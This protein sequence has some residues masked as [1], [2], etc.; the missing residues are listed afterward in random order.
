MAVSSL[1][2][3][4]GAL[5][6]LF[7]IK[8]NLDPAD[9]TAGGRGAERAIRYGRPR[10]VTVMVR[11]FAQVL[12]VTYILTGVLGFLFTGFQGGEVIT[13]L[14]FDFNPVHNALHAVVG[15]AFLASSVNEGLARSV[16]TL[17]GGTYL[18]IGLVGLLLIGSGDLISNGDL[19]VLALNQADNV[20]HILSGGLAVYV[21]LAGEEDTAVAG[22]KEEEEEPPPLLGP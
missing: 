3:T 21:G 2:R 20:L 7:G 5:S 11:R 18:A 17:G 4:I 6:M 15:L 10:R 14:I 1:G 12:G 13:L 9:Q 19:N 22:V 16:C 8:L